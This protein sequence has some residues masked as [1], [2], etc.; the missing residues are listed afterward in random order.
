[1]KLEE[2]IEKINE[3]NKHI[4]DKKDLIISINIKNFNTKYNDVIDSLT[5]INNE[6]TS[7][8]EKNIIEQY[9]ENNSLKINS[10][11]Y[12]YSQIEEDDI[13]DIEEI[14]RNLL[15]EIERLEYLRIFNKSNTIIVGGNGSGKSSLASY[16]KKSDADGI[17]VIPAQK[18]LFYLE[19]SG[20]SSAN[21][22]NIREIQKKDFNDKS[23]KKEFDVSNKVSQ[24]SEV[25]S[26]HIS[27]IINEL[28]KA[29]ADKLV[30]NKDSE[31]KYIKLLE[32]WRRFY[33]DIE[34]RYDMNKRKLV[35]E[36]NGKEYDLNS[37]SEGEKVTLFYIIITLFAPRNAYIIV[38]EPETFLNPSIY[39]RLWYLLEEYRE[40]CRFVYISHHLEFILSRN[41][42]TIYWCKEY[43]GNKNWEIKEI[44]GELED[45]PKELVIELLGTRKNI[46]FCEG[47]KESLDY[48]VYTLLF[49]NQ[50]VVIPVGGHKDVINNTKAYNNSKLFDGEAY[51]IIDKDYHGE[52]ALCNYEQNK[53]YHL[54]FNEIEMFLITNEIL[55]CVLTSIYPPDK[56]SVLMKKFKDE[57]INEIQT[58]KDYIINESIKFHIDEKSFTIDSKQLKDTEPKFVKYNAKNIKDYFCN[59][60]DDIKI[61]EKIKELDNKISKLVKENKYE[62]ALKVSNLKYL[63]Y[64]TTKKEFCLDYKSSCIFRIQNDKDLRKT[65]RD[66]YFS[67]LSNS[68]EAND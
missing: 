63:F 37:M 23:Y 66:T 2:F 57:V 34:F 54:E 7:L 45:I 20:V 39:N 55:E 38:D 13:K 50:V 1:M 40:D 6:K 30:E 59:L 51:G 4:S 49:E 5:R 21:E 19:K 26:Y 61:D 52:E 65:L 16:F 17:I 33:S 67:K 48:K 62:E 47:S 25:F 41:A 14:L 3:I 28:A 10:V 64:Y 8:R 56:S 43:D 9:I 31:T 11:Y 36:K 44:S 53:I 27:A 32:I 68:L 18:I 24:L 46:L 58:K 12:K 42:H 15:D 22:I 60:I 29:G 35:P